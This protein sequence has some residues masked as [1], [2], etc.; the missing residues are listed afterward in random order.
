MITIININ[1]EISVGGI[2]GVLSS[3]VLGIIFSFIVTWL[4]P[5]TW[6]KL[7]LL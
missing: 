6:T 7:K 1:E 4:I 2:S 3:Y 5:I